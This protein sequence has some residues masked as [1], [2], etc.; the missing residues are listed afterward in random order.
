M[1][2]I[3]IKPIDWDENDV[4]YTNINDKK[5]YEYIYFYLYNYDDSVKKDIITYF[6]DLNIEIIENRIKTNV[7]YTENMPYEIIFKIKHIED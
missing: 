3:N 1:D 2:S 7:I 5:K 4:P 6:K